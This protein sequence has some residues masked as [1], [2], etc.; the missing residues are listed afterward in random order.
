MAV[1]VN[2]MFH[3]KI[4]VKFYGSNTVIISVYSSEMGRAVTQLVESLRHKTGGYGFYFQSDPWKFSSDLFF[5]LSALRSPVGTLR[6]ARR[7]DNFVV[8]VVLNVR[9]RLEAQLSIP[10]LSLHDLLTV[11][12]YLQFN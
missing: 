5:F 10:H 1:N 6:P 2:Y 7:A 3:F 8:L 12:H 4:R 11:K 9:G